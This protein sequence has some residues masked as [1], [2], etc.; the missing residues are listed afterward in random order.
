MRNNSQYST[1]NP[2]TMQQQKPEIIKIR[3]E[4]SPLKQHTKALNNNT[5]A[6]QPMQLHL[7]PGNT[8]KVQGITL[9]S[10]WSKKMDE[11]LSRDVSKNTDKENNNAIQG[12]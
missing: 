9:P 2:I 7:L 10:C 6:V 4:K 1:L 8:G 5:I 11:R 12:K 3:N